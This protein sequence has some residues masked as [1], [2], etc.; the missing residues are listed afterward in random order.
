MRA[1]EEIQGGNRQAAV[2]QNIDRIRGEV[3]DFNLRGVFVSLDS[4]AEAALDIPDKG[5]DNATRQK[6]NAAIYAILINYVGAAK[7]AG[8]N[9][10]QYAAG[11]RLVEEIERAAT[12]NALNGGV[13][14]GYTVPVDIPVV[15]EK[16]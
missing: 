14:A 7:A 9:Y 10:E 6:A 4:D 11:E 3:S 8:W 5:P 15:K 16:N 2:N 1:L 12:G 13:P